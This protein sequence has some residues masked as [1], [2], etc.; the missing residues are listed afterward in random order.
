MNLNN[1]FWIFLISNFSS[2][3]DIYTLQINAD[4]SIN[5]D[6][7]SYFLFVGRIMGKIFVM[8]II[9]DT[10]IAYHMIFF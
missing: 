6:H 3:D 4:S 10:R 9:A 7:L 1:L 5:P 2:R 8:N